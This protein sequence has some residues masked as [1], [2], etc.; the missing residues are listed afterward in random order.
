MALSKIDVANMLT[1]ATP[2]ANGG[3]ALTS[4][5]VNGSAL[6][7]DTWRI[8]SNFQ[9]NTDPVTANWERD[10]TYGNGVSNGMTES[11][12]IFTFPSTGFWLVTAHFQFSGDSG[13]N[14]YVLLNI[15]VST[16]GG[17]GYADA[18]FG[19]TNLDGSGEYAKTSIQKVLD[20]T[21]TSQIRVSFTTTS[22][23]NNHYVQC[24]SN[25]NASYAIFQR[26][27]DT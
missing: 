2:V 1:G 13:D 19:Y 12:G 10:D 9:G 27:G 18:A 21:D 11:S 8:T 24:D 20:V 6:G 5:F 17:T 7:I 4:G 3:T 26:L 23:D 15:N 14:I 22:Q 25:Q 16:N